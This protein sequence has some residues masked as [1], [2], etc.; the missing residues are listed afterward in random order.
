MIENLSV[1]APIVNSNETT[2][3]TNLKTENAICQILE[4]KPEITGW[5]HYT[6]AEERETKEIIAIMQND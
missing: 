4:T 5:L 2:T 3:K 6:M 1:N